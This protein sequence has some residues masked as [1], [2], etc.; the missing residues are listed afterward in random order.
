[1]IEFLKTTTQK[2]GVYDRLKFTPF[3]DLYIAYRQPVLL[4]LRSCEIHLYQSLGLKPGDLVFD[5]GANQGDK[6]DVFLRIGTTVVAIDPDKRNIDILQKRFWKN[7]KIS[8]IEKAVGEKEERKTFFIANQGSSFN[9]LSTKWR[10]VLQNES[11]SRF[12]APQQF[13]SSYDVSVT[14]LDKLIEQ[15]GCPTFIKIDVEG[16]E[17]NVIEG[18]S[19]SVKY[20]SFELNLP[21]FL[22][23]GLQCLSLLY[24]L[25]Q[26]SVML[27]CVTDWQEGF[28]WTDWREVTDVEDL[29][30]SG[31]IRYVEVFCKMQ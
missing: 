23:E 21:E 14:T 9:T 5:V 19:H 26:G 30:K 27:N 8:I 2:L 4:K 24:D 7:E 22:Q 28:I 25:G 12:A 10:D 3:Y 13:N 18:L 16:Y 31:V 20:L 1:M 29:I 15:F 17:V 6:S 11:L